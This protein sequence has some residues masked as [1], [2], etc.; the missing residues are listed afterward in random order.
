MSAP[1]RGAFC[2]IPV[3]GTLIQIWK[4]RKTDLKFVKSIFKKLQS[5]KKVHKEA[6]QIHEEVF[7]EIDCLECANCCTTIPPIISKRDE[8][9]I[10]AHLNISTEKFKNTYIRV[11]EDGDAVLNSIPCT[12]LEEDNKC[13]I[14][15]VRPTA[16]RQYPHTGEM[17]FYKNL[18]LHKRNVKYCPALLE[19]VTRLAAIK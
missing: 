16:C 10:A 18:S 11:D 4:A 9:R 3:M 1:L 6:Q 15:E 8:K 5:Q 19:I 7:E 14:Y 2:Y 13:R 17:E 12:F